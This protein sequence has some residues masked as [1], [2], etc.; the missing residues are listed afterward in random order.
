M[1]VNPWNI[2]TLIQFNAMN[3]AADRYRLAAFF[4]HGSKDFYFNGN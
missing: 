3:E 4:D 1:Q 2:N